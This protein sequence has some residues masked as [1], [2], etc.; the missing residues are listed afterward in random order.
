MACLLWLTNAVQL[1]VHAV[2]PN[3]V[4]SLF[5]MRVFSPVADFLFCFVYCSLMQR[6]IPEGISECP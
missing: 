1:F 6:T 4:V 5:A 2:S 3:R